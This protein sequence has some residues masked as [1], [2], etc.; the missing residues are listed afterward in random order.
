LDGL[1]FEH[2]KRVQRMMNH[3]HNGKF[4]LRQCRTS[5]ERCRRAEDLLV[6]IDEKVPLAV[7]EKVALAATAFPGRSGF[8]VRCGAIVHRLFDQRAQ[9]R[10]TA[11]SNT[12]GNN[13][14]ALPT[15]DP[16]ASEVGVFYEKVAP[17][18]CHRF[19]HE[20]TYLNES[21]WLCVNESAALEAS[22]SD[23]SCTCRCFSAGS[24]DWSQTVGQWSEPFDRCRPV[25]SCEF[26]EV[27]CRAGAWP[28][29]VYTNF[30]S[31][32]VPKP[33]AGLASGSER[34]PWLSVLVLV[35]DSTSQSNL[36][37]C[38]PKLVQALRANYTSVLLRG[39]AKVADNSFPNAVAAFTGKRFDPDD[40]DKSELPIDLRHEQF[41][42]WPL[43]WR[44]FASKRQHT[45]LFAEDFPPFNLFTYQ[46]A[47]FRQPP[48][49]H[50][51]RPFAWRVWRSFLHLRSTHLCVG[52]TPTHRMLLDYV[53]QFLRRYS[54]RPT[55]AVG[56]L[57]EIT[58]DWLNQGQVADADLAD[59][60]NR[61]RPFLTNTVTVLVSDH[62][63]RFGDIRHTRLGRLEENMPAMV[64]VLPDNAADRYPKLLETVQR[65]AALLATHYDLHATLVDLLDNGD[66]WTTLEQRLADARPPDTARRAHSLLLPLPQDRGCA[67]ADIPD[68][69]CVCQ[70]TVRRDNNE[71][72]TLNAGRALV[73]ELNRRLA[74][75]HRCA[76]L[77]LDRLLY[78]G[79]LEVDADDATTE[80]SRERRRYL[81][82]VQTKPGNGHFEAIVHHHH[83]PQQQQQQ[84]HWTVPEDISRIN[85]YG[86]QSFCVDN[87]VLKKYCFCQ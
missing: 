60:F 2:L 13:G 42:H 55:F 7:V 25:R 10:R 58:H 47:G 31:Q 77:R 12:R 64:L 50:Y 28:W 75:E 63:L 16:W 45:T 17:L 73:A 30:H 72:E 74:G 29:S 56:W 19:Q 69:Y 84:Q 52:N 1:V 35:V 78:A 59:F 70:T 85:R 54:D 27:S 44:Q 87:A 43:I 37:R 40:A 4:F 15:L 26:V 79:E 36:Q 20:L 18:R 65:N 34:R 3:N 76:T 24:D 57:A 82:Q 11:A 49:D 67:E 22:Y 51:Y 6:V 66:T 68:I 9:F 33:P 21:G 23:V 61:A 5:V 81:I 53:G 48:A 62:G 38:F 39:Y 83:R 41:D 32:I 8:R 71:T 14:C 46:A 80:P 86:N